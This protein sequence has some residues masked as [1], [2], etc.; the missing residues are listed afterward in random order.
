MNTGGIPI[1]EMLR[2]VPNKL[3]LQKTFGLL[4][5]T[6]ENDFREWEVSRDETVSSTPARGDGVLGNLSTAAQS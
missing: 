2:G 5:A 4:R 3:A 1:P 6:R